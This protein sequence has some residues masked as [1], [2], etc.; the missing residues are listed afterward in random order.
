MNY[1]VTQVRNIIKQAENTV[2]QRSKFKYIRIHYE[3][4][5]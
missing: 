1:S 3:A 2:R 4:D 5:I